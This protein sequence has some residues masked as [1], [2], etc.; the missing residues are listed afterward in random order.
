MIKNAILILIVIANLSFSTQKKKKFIPPGVVQ[1]TETFFADECEISNLSWLEY[2]FW[3]KEKYGYHSR[4]HLKTLPDTLVWRNP[5]SLN[6]PYVTYYYR[7]KSYHNF[8]VVGIS[9]EQA[10]AFCKWRSDRVKEYYYITYKKELNLE[11]RLPSEKE[12]ELISNNGQNIFTN[13]GKNEKGLALLNCV[14]QDTIQEKIANAEKMDVTAPVYSYWQNRFGLFNTFGNV[15]EM[16]DEKGISKG[17]GWRHKLEECRAGKNIAY[18]KPEA[19]LGFRCVC[20][21]KQ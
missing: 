11:Y 2:E 15:S 13:K 12:W 20:V 4:E 9:Y 1:I 8:P 21:Y 18:T 10:L 6:E 17:G 14:R 7:H 5:E 16:I 3:T 19:W